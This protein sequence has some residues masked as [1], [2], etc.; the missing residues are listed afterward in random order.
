MFDPKAFDD[1]AKKMSELMPP[2]MAELKRDFE[3]NSKAALQS[4]FTKMDLVTREE[5][6]VQAGVL[7]KTREKLE[8]LEATVAELETR[9]QITEP[10][11]DTSA[12][13]D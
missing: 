12:P 5:F 13:K 6:D 11:A 4:M 8:A 10:G 3:N 7:A 1:F 2:G 9:L